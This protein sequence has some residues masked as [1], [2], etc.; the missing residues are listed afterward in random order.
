MTITRPVLLHGCHV[1][2]D[3]GRSSI[4]GRHRRIGVVA[5]A[6]P[7]VDVVAADVM[8]A[9]VAGVVAAVAVAVAGVVVV[10]VA[11]FSAGV[12]LVGAAA[13]EATGPAASWRRAHSCTN[14]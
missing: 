1:T 11:V 7:V 12:A 6:P 10:V 8:E 14:V 4:V 2:T 13:A 9:A 5:A 3:A